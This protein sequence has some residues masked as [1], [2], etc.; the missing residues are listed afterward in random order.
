MKE[1]VKVAVAQMAPVFLDKKATVEKAC[2]II[3]EASKNGANLVVFP[4]T[5]VP[6][7]PDWVWVV[8]GNKKP[9]L[10][11]LYAKL[12]ENSIS[13]QDDTTRKLGQSAKKNKVHLVLG[14]SEKNTEASGSSLFN[15]LLFFG[16]NG[17]LMGKRR[18][19]TPTGCERIIWAQ[20][21]GSTLSAFDTPLGRL[22][23]LICWE[24][25]MPLARQAMYSFGTKILISATWDSSEV[26]LAS[27]RHI[28]KE[29][30][31]FVISSCTALKM[32]DIPDAY[33]FKSLYPEG[34]EWVNP[35]NSCVV[36]PNGTII[37][38]PLEKKQ[39]ILYAELDMNLI[40]ASKWM[41]DT[42]GHYARPDV[43]RFELKRD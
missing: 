8:P 21:D 42:A 6:A 11:E 16:D 23:G 10:N 13:V 5:F 1:S 4:E 34:R 7:Y 26:W 15:S 31:C 17:E 30:G 2:E 33:E 19:L 41:L 38:G 24:T 12:L 35:G 43:F 3:S 36:A 39:E 40:P 22:G 28:A 32:E 9:I 25:Y 27:M 14:V 37:A 29:G 18:K 20:G